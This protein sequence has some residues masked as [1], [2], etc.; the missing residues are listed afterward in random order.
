MTGNT[1]P[2]HFYWVAASPNQLKPEKSGLYEEISVKPIDESMKKRSLLI[3]APKQQN[4][5]D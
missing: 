2:L 1:V 3:K 4:K 5:P